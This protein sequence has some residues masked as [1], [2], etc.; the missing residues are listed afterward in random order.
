ME[1][2]APLQPKSLRDDR[3]G[4]GGIDLRGGA[5]E[6]GPV[7]GLVGAGVAP[8]GEPDFPDEAG[9]LDGGMHVPAHPLRERYTQMLGSQDKRTRA[10]A[11]RALLA[12]YHGG[13]CN[14]CGLVVENFDNLYRWHFDHLADLQDYTHSPRTGMFQF[15]ISGNNC[16]NRK[17]QNVFRHGMY[18]TQLLCKNC[19]YH[20]NM[21][22]F[23]DRQQY[24]QAVVRARDILGL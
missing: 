18:D 1:I 20:K 24:A 5:A 21:R 11:I 13:R 2:G 10:I 22:T 17:L 9:E 16:V 8:V 4:V 7:R 15:R 23:H 3:P 19:H 14:Q 6:P 12:I